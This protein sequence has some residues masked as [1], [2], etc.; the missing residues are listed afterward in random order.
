MAMLGEEVGHHRASHAYYVLYSV[1]GQDALL[2]T[3]HRASKMGPLKMH[4]PK[5]P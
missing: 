2:L 5:L 1:Q 3:R 4:N